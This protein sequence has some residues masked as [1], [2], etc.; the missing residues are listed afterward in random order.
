MYEED[1]IE[2]LGSRGRYS[3]ALYNNIMDYIYDSGFVRLGSLSL[4]V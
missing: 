4:G 3:Y 2:R 1:I